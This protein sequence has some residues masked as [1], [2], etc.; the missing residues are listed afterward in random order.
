MGTGCCMETN[1]T[2]NFI[3]FKK[4]D[5][6]DSGRTGESC[7]SK[8]KLYIG[9]KA[10]LPTGRAGSVFLT[11]VPWHSMWQRGFTPQALPQ[12]EAAQDRS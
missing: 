12:L 2:I 11:S 10:K 8:P 3:F 1:L 4:V 5:T 7:V 6:L 9:R